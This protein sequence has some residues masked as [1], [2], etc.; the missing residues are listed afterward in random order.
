M[1]P[2]LYEEKPPRSRLLNAD[3]WAAWLGRQLDYSAIAK[4]IA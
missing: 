4:F 1:R 3:R 2:S